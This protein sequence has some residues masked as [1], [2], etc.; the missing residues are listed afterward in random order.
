M[1]LKLQKTL[2]ALSDPIRRQILTNLKQGSLSAGEIASQFDVSG[3]A[4]SRHLSILKDAGL[5]RC[6]RKGKFLVYEI[7]LSVLEEVLQWLTDLKE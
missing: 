1:L 7:N 5:V 4:I 6:Q 2:Q 3:P